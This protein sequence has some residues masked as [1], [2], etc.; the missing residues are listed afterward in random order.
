MGF[1]QTVS[2]DIPD[3]LFGG[4]I[5]ENVL[6]RQTA[7]PSVMKLFFNTLMAAVVNFPLKC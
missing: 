5:G 3:L 2:H 7:Y 4:L 1:M 6:C